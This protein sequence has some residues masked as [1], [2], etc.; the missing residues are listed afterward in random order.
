MKYKATNPGLEMLVDIANEPVITFDEVE[1]PTADGNIAY[2]HGH[3]SW[4]R[5]TSESDLSQFTGQWFTLES[6]EWKIEEC[7]LCTDGTIFYRR[8]SKIYR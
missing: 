3:H 7:I 6:D 5:L 8:A 1:I 4:N 2:V